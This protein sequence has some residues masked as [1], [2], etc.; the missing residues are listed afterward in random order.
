[1]TAGPRTEPTVD[2]ADFVVIGGGSAGASVARRLADAG[3]DVLVI[4]AGPTAEFDDRVLTSIARPSYSN[5]HLRPSRQVGWTPTAWSI[6]SRLWVGA[7]NTCTS[8]QL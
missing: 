4:E 5:G 3:A 1:M 8:R 7:T 2:A 6:R